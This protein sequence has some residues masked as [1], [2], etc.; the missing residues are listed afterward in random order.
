MEPSW[1]PISDLTSGGGYTDTFLK[2]DPSVDSEERLKLAAKIL[3]DPI[4]Q[5]KLSDR[6]YELMLADLQLQN[7]RHF[8]Y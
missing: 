1:E 6:V 5:I 8:N 7:E 4:L 2:K 3:K